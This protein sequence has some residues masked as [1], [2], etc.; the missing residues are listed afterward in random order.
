MEQPWVIKVGGHEIA[1]EAYV[2]TLGGFIATLPMPVIV[3]H[4]GGKE[5]SQLQ[6]RYGL[7]PQMVDGVRVTD[8]PTLEIVTMVLSGLVNKRLVAAFMGAGLDA[9]GIS[10]VDRGIVRA[11]K[12]AHDTF[13][14]QYTGSV[15]SVDAAKLIPLL[16][17]GMTPVI[18]PICLGA[19]ALYNVNADHV[20]GA[21]AGALG[22]ERVIFLTNVEGVLIDGVVAPTISAVEAESYIANETIYGGMVPKVRTA[23]KAL[24]MGVTGAVITNLEGLRTHGGTVFSRS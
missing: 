15:T 3:V 6:E 5:I 19:D 18:A 7:T 9:L 12:M 8:T 14:M 1:D 20:A 2:Q 16:H 23:L 22:A 17:A 21:I 10:G 11:G 13:D 4:G 24:E